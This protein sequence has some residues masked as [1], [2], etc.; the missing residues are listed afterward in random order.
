MDRLVTVVKTVVKM[1]VKPEGFGI[2]F[3][4]SLTREEVKGP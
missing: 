2:G 1:V 3:S 4:G